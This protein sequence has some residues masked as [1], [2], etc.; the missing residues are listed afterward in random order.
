VKKHFL[1]SVALP[2]LLSGTAMAADLPVKAPP[3][4]PAPE[5][6]S[7]TGF[8]A[9]LNAGGAWGKFDPTTTVACGPGPPFLFVCSPTRDQTTAS[10]IAAAGTGSM[11]GSGFTGG[12]QVGAN[13]QSGNAVF[14]AEADFG[15][16]HIKASRQ[17][18]EASEII[19][20]PGTSFAV[21]N[22]ASTDWL[23][24]ARG[25]LGW[26]FGNLLVYAT[27]G[28]AVT[29]LHTNNTYTD[30]TPIGSAASWG[31]T[32]NKAGW[33]VGG[34]LEWALSRNLSVKAEYLYLKFDSV[35]QA[36]V[37]VNPFASGYANAIAT[38]TDL[39]AHIARAGVNYRF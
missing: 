37:I 16:F 13:W 6:F 18:S 34:G 22:S 31:G 27:G 24:T 32:T 23:F 25:R 10:T 7:W 11:S 30:T 21:T 38:S 33:T 39:T 8:Y 15:A 2:A 19:G 4:P 5:A 1:G 35:N 14:G 28:L 26:A 3:L 36:G 20:I 29:D 9:G 17:V 12:L